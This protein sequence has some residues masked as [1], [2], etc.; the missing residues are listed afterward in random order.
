MRRAVPMLVAALTLGGCID[1]LLGVE[2]EDECSNEGER[3][4][5]GSQ[6]QECRVTW[7]LSLCKYWNKVADC[8]DR[9]AVCSDGECLCPPELADC[10]SCAD[11]RTD[12]NHCGSCEVHCTT[13]CVDGVCSP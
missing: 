10:G 12:P 3:T 5:D 7:W 13:A 6:V 11:L 1:A 4:C 8:G 2:C 9:Q